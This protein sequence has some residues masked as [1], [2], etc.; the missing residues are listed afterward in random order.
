MRSSPTITLF[1]E[2]RDVSQRSTSFV[3]SIL[4]HCMG[5][6]LFSFGVMYTPRLDPK[7]IARRYAVRNI[8]LATPEQQ[9]QRAAR[10]RV[11]YP[12]QPLKPA[13]AKPGAGKPAARLAEVPRPGERRLGVGGPPVR[14]PRLKRRRMSVTTVEEEH[15]GH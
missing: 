9:K 8:D 6:L 4:F 3:V 1:T 14:L 13:P 15:G 7:A 12:G 2:N 11:K 5:L 10:S